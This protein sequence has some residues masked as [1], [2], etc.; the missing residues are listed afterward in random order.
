[1]TDRLYY[2]VSVFVYLRR[3]ILSKPV[4]SLVHWL[5]DILKWY[6]LSVEII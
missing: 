1:M 3:R 6:L 5:T 2:T 4:Y